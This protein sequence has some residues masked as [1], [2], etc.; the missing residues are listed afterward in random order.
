MKVNF[1][2]NTLR[3]IFFCLTRNKFSPCPRTVFSQT[4][5]IKNICLKRRFQFVGR[6]TTNWKPLPFCQERV[7]LFF[8][9]VSLRQPCLCFAQTKPIYATLFASKRLTL[10]FALPPFYPLLQRSIKKNAKRND[11]LLSSSIIT[12]L[13]NG[14]KRWQSLKDHAHA[15]DYAIKPLH[16]LLRFLLRS[17]SPY[18]WLPFKA[19]SNSAIWHRKVSHTIIIVLSYET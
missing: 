7:S 6:K 11:Y 9:F 1:K 4:Q 16:Y 2:I 10:S 12:K 8:R 14:L 19:W 18:G 17:F 13:A 3:G 15:K 5:K